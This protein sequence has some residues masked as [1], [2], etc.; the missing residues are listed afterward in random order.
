[1]AKKATQ[2]GKSIYYFGATK[3]EGRGDQK[4]LLGGKGANLAEMTSIGLPVPPGFTIT[5]EVCDQ[6]NKGKGK[7]PAGLMDEVAK[8]VGLLEKETGKKFGDN[9]NPLL[10]SV[11]SGAAASMPGMMNTILNLGL[12]DEAVVGLA[13]ATGNERFAYDAYRRLI[14]M[15]G[16]V[17]VGVDH[18]H[19]EEAFDKIK[20]KHNA[21]KDTDVPTKGLIELC[22][23]YKK[24]YKKYHGEPFPQ[25]PLQQLEMAIE[26]VFKSWNQPRAVKYRQVENITGL[27]GTAVNVQS[28]VF[29]NMGEDS[30]TGVAFTRDPATF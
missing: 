1:M 28:M 3:T 5:T 18:E 26:A 25:S 29:G 16:D 17:V 6:Y 21:Q 13:T 7:L 22:E 20:R 27:L 15:Y 14:N 24:V 19:F 10:V 30:G 4:E 9:Q 12:N 23:A 8:A 11:L 2:S